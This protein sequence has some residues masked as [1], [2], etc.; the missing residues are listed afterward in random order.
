MDLL[1]GPAKIPEQVVTRLNADSNAYLRLEDTKVLLS[2][3][4]LTPLGG[5]PA[6]LK[7]R[8]A[9]EIELWRPVIKAANITVD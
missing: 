1:L 4:G 2:K 6:D 8:M 7:R 3:L 5:T 9:T